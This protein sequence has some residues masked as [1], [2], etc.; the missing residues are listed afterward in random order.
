MQPSPDYF[1]LLLKFYLGRLLV[2]NISLVAPAIIVPRV[3]LLLCLCSQQIND[4]D[5][6]DDDEDEGALLSYLLTM[7]V[8]RLP[9]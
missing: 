6:D 1:D 4:D 7:Q 8:R 3:L 2:L 5:D 9:W